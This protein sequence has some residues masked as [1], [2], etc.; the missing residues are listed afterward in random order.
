[1]GLTGDPELSAWEK[2][3][4]QRLMGARKFLLFSGDTIS[5]PKSIAKSIPPRIGV[6]IYIY[7]E[8]FTVLEKQ[9]N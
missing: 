3:R 7:V 8:I 4:L 5:C 1:M 9:G 2:M 6:Y